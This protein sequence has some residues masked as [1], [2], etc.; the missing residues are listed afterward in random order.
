MT[1][2]ILILTTLAT[3]LIAGLFYAYTCS[4]NP[5]LAKLSDEGY[6]LAMQS[7][8]R[9][10]LNP[11][12]FASFIGTLLLLPL[13]TW[14]QYQSGGRCIAFYLLFAATLVYAIGTFGVTITGNV[15]LNEALDKFNVKS[16]SIEEIAIQRQLFE[17]QWNKLN[18]IRTIANIV[19]LIMVIIACINVSNSQNATG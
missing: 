14:L 13:S 2:F 8:N 6:I 9:A 4:V 11:V 5:G 16:A 3:A 15:P 18:N 7:I 10:I 12:F 1:T 17:M 19:S